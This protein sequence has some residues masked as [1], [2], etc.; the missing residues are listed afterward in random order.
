M[1]VRIVYF[2]A[3]ETANDPE[4]NARL[5]ISQDFSEPLQSAPSIKLTGEQREQTQSNRAHAKQKK[6]N[7]NI[8]FYVCL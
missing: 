8:G 1:Q 5:G 3:A 7:T 4:V 6:E 2:N